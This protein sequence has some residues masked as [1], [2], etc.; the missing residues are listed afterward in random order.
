MRR[1][2]RC[3]QSNLAGLRNELQSYAVVAPSFS[4][5]RRA[6]VEDM[7]MVAAATRTVIFGA[8]QNQFEIRAGLKGAWNARKKARPACAA[9]VFHLGGEERQA[10][11]RA[12]VNSR[13]LLA[14]QRARAGRL[15]AL[16][17]QNVEFIRRQSLAPLLFG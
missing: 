13:A 8:W 12:G 10:A 9:V 2:Q 6:V 11:A 5:G 4:G 14:I 1:C 7:A 3:A 17:T 15:R 16:L